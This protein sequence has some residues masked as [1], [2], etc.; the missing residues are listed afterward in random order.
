MEPVEVFISFHEADEE[1]LQDLERHLGAL[2]RERMITCW[3]SRKIV[4]GEERNAEIDKHLNQAGIILLLMSSHFLDSEY[5]WTVEVTRALERNES[6]KARTT[7][8]LLRLVDWEIKPIDR[9][10]LLP[11]NRLPIKKWEDRDEAFV[12]VVNGI[13]EEL[14]C[15]A[16]SRA[17]YVVP[18]PMVDEKIQH[19]ITR[20]INEGDRFY[21]QDKLEEAIYKYREALSLDFRNVL[22]HHNLG[23]V[24]AKQNNLEEAILEFEQV[25]KLN[26]NDA[27]AYYNLG[28]I[29]KEKSELEEAVEKYRKAIS[30]DPTNDDAHC[31]LGNVLRIQGELNKAILECKISLHLDPKKAIA[32]GIIGTALKQKGK[33]EEAILE[34]RK[35]L[36]LEST[37]AKLHY[38]LASILDDQGNLE[39]AASE[40]K[41]AI[42]YAPDYTKAYYSLG[43]VLYK[44]GKADQAIPRYRKAIKLD[45]NYAIAYHELGIALHN[46]GKKGAI[47][48]LKQA[49]VIEP[50]NTLFQKNLI[51]ISLGK[52]G[53]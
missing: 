34:Y 36:K 3:H 16:I 10:P 19:Q 41:K 33:I 38:N 47:L 4:A 25:I 45:P 5:H 51:A 2:R 43:R 12:K 28:N 24:L 22:A 17:N 30:I 7:V 50:N 26:P 9:L 1:F 13:R 11:R 18:E 48:A 21:D 14:Q 23:V 35:A 37:N 20:L 8:V 53:I 15:L 39:E 29:F 49:I 44:Q 42:R 52:K 32:H 40:Y 6:G 27:D 31:N 46:Q